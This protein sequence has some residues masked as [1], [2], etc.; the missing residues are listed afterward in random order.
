[1]ERRSTALVTVPYKVSRADVTHCRES[2]LSK[3][4]FSA[5]KPIPNSQTNFQLKG[6][7]KIKKREKIEAAQRKCGRRTPGSKHLTH[8]PSHIK[9]IWR[10]PS[11]PGTA[12]G[13]LSGHCLR[14]FQQTKRAA[15]I[16]P[17]IQSSHICGHA[18]THTH[19]HAYCH[20]QSQDEIHPPSLSLSSYLA[21][22][23]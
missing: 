12:S 19:R 9:R 10:C 6:E 5:K 7:E 17:E 23:I 14:G 21:S 20:T 3:C 2:Q 11:S 13:S 1:M 8:I 22:D 15:V 4:A 16:L 18:H